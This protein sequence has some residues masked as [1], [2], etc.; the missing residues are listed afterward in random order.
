[1]QSRTDLFRLAAAIGGVPILGCLDGSPAAEAGVRYGDI[2]LSV[3]GLPTAT[4]D[5]FLEAR[6]RSKGGFLARIFR[7]GDEFEVSIEFRRRENKSPLEVLGELVS[8][9]VLVH[10]APRGDTD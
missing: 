3:D 10:A 5:D 9:D 2:L 8:R 4:W 7:G 1:M 6:S